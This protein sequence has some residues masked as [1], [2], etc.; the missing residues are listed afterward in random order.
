[1]V[2]GIVEIFDFSSLQSLFTFSG[3]LLCST[4]NADPSGASVFVDLYHP[5]AQNRKQAVEALVNMNKLSTMP[6]SDDKKNLLVTGIAQRLS[7][8][9]PDVVN[10]VLKFKTEDLIKIIGEAN[11]IKKLKS[12]IGNEFM[13]QKKWQNVIGSAVKHI[14]SKHLLSESNE[15]EIFLAILPYMFSVNETAFD[16]SKAII[17]SGIASRFPIVKQL[18][19]CKHNSENHLDAVNKLLQNSFDESK[20]N[21]IVQF[22]KTTPEAEMSTMSAFH[23]INLLTHV[24]MKNSNHNLSTA[25]FDVV[26][27]L[28]QRFDVRP[29]DINQYVQELYGKNRPEKLSVQLIEQCVRAIIEKT[30]FSAVV[31]SKTIDFTLATDELCLV[32][33]IH[34]HICRGLFNKLTNSFYNRVMSRFVRILLPSIEKQLDFFSNFFIVHH[35]DR[36]ASMRIG[37]EVQLRSIRILNE[38]L[39]HANSLKDLTMEVFVRIISGLTS[40]FEAI[41][42]LTIDTIDKLHALL[43]QSSEY[44]KFFGLILREK[45]KVCMSPEELSLFLFQTKLKRTDL[46]RFIQRPDTAMVLKASSLNMLHLVNDDKLDTMYLKIVIDVALDILKRIDGTQIT[47]LG[48]LESI[49]VYHAIIRFNSENISSISK[50]GN[51]RTFFEFVLQQSNVYVEDIDNKLQSISVVAMNLNMFNDFPKFNVNQQKFIVESIVKATTFAKQNDVRTRASKFFRKTV[52]L[53]GKIEINILT[54]MVQVTSIDAAKRKGVK[55]LSQDLLQTPEW[56]C[57]VTLLEFL[58]RKRLKNPLHLIRQLFPVL[59]KCLDFDDQSMVEYAKQLVLNDIL[60]CCSLL[61]STV[62]FQ[63]S[64]FKIE[65]VVQC[66]RGTQNPQTHHHALQLL[67][68]L[69]TRIPESVLHHIMEIFT[70]VGCTVVRRDDDYIYQLISN[71]IKSVVPILKENNIIQV[72]RAFS[73]IIID[74]PTHRR[75]ALYEDLLKTLGPREYLWMFMAI[76]FEKD[77]RQMDG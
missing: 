20:V 29:I 44:S 19:A 11:L 58:H 8:D 61:P 75:L 36:L 12:I 56:K 63:E 55:C 38:L 62:E 76:V 9:S 5:S 64:D 22:I 72:L 32:L 21:E 60:N 33:K 35:I 25:V 43:D 48:P 6:F 42:L 10:E 31:S 57:G 14:T 41:R 7:D 68:E 69:A 26:M 74:V 17:K 40:P 37:A 77:V 15:I 73:V 4:Y 51:Y 23:V 70:F 54:K 3:A 53:D 71:V 49:V 2:S 34:D 46:F 66:V 18:Q 39:T 50:P 52:E 16:H 27:K 67:T 28:S 1:M 30:N 47:V 13:A 65:L 45:E 59:Q 24:L